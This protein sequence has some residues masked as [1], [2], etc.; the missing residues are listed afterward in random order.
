MSEN[1]HIAP[2]TIQ[3]L[4]GSGGMADVYLA[5]DNVNRWPVALKILRAAQSRDARLLK[6]LEQEAA[7]LM[8]LRHPH[9]VQIYDANL[10]D[11]GRYYIAMEYVAG[12]D[13]V[14]LMQQRRGK[15]NITESLYLMRRVAGTIAYVHER[16]IVHRDLKP[17]NILLRAD[18]G[19]PLIADLGIA[20]LAGGNKLTGTSEAIGTPQYMAP[21]QT[22][23][24]GT[25]DGRA[26][27]YAIGVMLFEL[28][29]GRL[30]LDA[31]NTWALLMRKQ[32]EPA[33]SIL[34]MRHDLDPRLATVID[35][36]LQRDPAARFATAG[37]L[38]M[39][40]DAFL[41]PDAGPPPPVASGHKK[42][43]G[44]HM[45]M[46]P[47][48]PAASWPNTPS[49]AKSCTRTHSNGTRRPRPKRLSSPFGRS[50]STT[51]P[52]SRSRSS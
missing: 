49:T 15:L 20:S 41:P 33:P 27:I 14:N 25:A 13:L 24:Q 4:L 44:S 23:G 19:E 26:D 22:I 38:A 21:E 10:L 6:R 9:I 11:D 30:P 3:E 16:G 37:A 12:G 34:T 52:A 36:C 51:C 31:D 48:T 46:K 17:S 18:T 50:T 39:T 7:L 29:T 35:T 2:Y 45:P 47:L 28:L 42:G 43:P 5:W 32:Y 40:L 8:K 1:I